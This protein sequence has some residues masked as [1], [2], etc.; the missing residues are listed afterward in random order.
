MSNIYMIGMDTSK[1]QASKVD[2]AKAKQNGFGFVILRIGYKTNKDKCFEADYAR[3]KAAGLKVGVY[4][5]TM[6]KE[7]TEATQDATRVLGWLNGRHLDLPVFFDLE[8]KTL[9]ST[10]RKAT[11]ALMYK[12]FRDK[13]LSSGQY[14][15]GLYSGEYF[16]NAYI[17]KDGIDDNLWIAKYSNNAPKVGKTVSIWQ[18]TS[19]AVKDTYY[20]GKLDRNYMLVQSLVMPPDYIKIVPKKNPYPEPTRNLKKTIPCMRG[21]DVKWLQWYL[22]VTVDGIFGKDTKNATIA[23]Q[24]THGLKVDGIVGSATRYALK[25]N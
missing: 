19:D 24:Q 2:Y 4:F 17:Q 25:N 9:A 5:Y 13:I 23:F 18:F 16:F 7:P 6:S 14:G 11:N 10:T 21:N 8:D 22:G 20:N 3:A 15:C 1:H 12:A